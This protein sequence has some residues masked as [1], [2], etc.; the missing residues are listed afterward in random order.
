VFNNIILNAAEA[1]ENGGLLQIKTEYDDMGSAVK[2][3]FTD[4]GHGI[5]KEELYNVLKPGYSLKE[6]GSGFGLSIVQRIVREHQGK[7][8]LTSV[9]DVGTT[10]TIYLPVDLEAVPIQTNL[11]MRPIFYEAPDDLIIDELA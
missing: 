6:K 11:Q 1:M 8:D 2:L 10:V 5:P 7:I 3:T 9:E 4:T